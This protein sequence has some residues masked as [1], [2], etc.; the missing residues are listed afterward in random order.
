M[1]K[2]R[3]NVIYADAEA[4]AIPDTTVDATGNFTFG[5]KTFDRFVGL[6][7]S[8]GAMQ[9]SVHPD[10]AGTEPD[11]RRRPTHRSTRWSRPT[12]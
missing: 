4:L 12:A 11:R 10:A 9:Y 3:N 2:H 8:S 1:A 7:V 6:S 5:W